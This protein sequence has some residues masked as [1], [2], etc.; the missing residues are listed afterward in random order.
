[1]TFLDQ[2]EMK[3]KADGTIERC[4]TAI[5]ADEW[6]EPTLQGSW[7]D[8]CYVVTDPLSATW[9]NQFDYDLALSMI[10]VGRGHDPYNHVGDYIVAKCIGVHIGPPIF[11][12]AE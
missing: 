6:A 8:C 11:A 7:P 9:E 4:G 10:N 12:E 3:F 2:A 1:M 5:Q